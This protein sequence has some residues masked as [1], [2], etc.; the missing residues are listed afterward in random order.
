MTWAPRWGGDYTHAEG[1]NDHGV[2]V[3]S[4]YLEGNITVHATLWRQIGTITDLGVLGGDQCSFASAINAK[5]QIVGAS[6]GDDCTFDNNTRAF[7]WEGG[8]IFDLN[9]LIPA[10]S[11]LHLQ[12][13]R[14]VND[15]GEIVGSGLD[16]DGNV[17]AFL[18]IPCDENHPGVEGCDYSMVDGPTGAQSEAP[19]YVR[20]GRPPLPESRSAN[21]YH[22][23]NL[24]ASRRD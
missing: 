22:L 14:G 13:A 21:R 20:S 5:T 4:A 6:M 10:G 23:P 3:G 15:R 11:P 18:V 17:H 19:R 9:A 12:W 16:A 2:T 7:L 1:I 8:S 24:G